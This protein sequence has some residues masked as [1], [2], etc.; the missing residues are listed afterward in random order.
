MLKGWVKATF[1]AD[2]GG[3]RVDPYLRE[4]IWLDPLEFQ[5]MI[6]EGI[7]VVDKEDE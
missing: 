1:D 4:D 3:F 6:D 2:S 5:E 7:I